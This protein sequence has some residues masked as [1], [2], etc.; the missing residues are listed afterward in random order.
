MLNEHHVKTH[1]HTHT[2]LYIVHT[3]CATTKVQNDALTVRIHWFKL[4]SNRLTVCKQHF[5]QKLYRQV[6]KRPLKKSHI[7]H[8]LTNK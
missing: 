8:T 7:N 5:E 4:L 6:C 1:T 3:R 2:R